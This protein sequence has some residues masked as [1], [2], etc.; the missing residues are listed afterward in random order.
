MIRWRRYDGVMLFVAAAVAGV[1][2]AHSTQW[3]TGLSMAVAVAALFVRPRTH[4]AAPVVAEQ[5]NLLAF[6]ATSG[7]SRSS[8]TPHR[9]VGQLLA[10]DA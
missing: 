9:R 10:Q 2:A 5:T 7:S 4:A 1:L 3:A 8:G 6:N